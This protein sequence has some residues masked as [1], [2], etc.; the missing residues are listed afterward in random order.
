M[1]KD[2]ESEMEM[3]RFFCDACE[4]GVCTLCTLTT[5]KTHKVIDIKSG[6]N[7]QKEKLQTSLS[8]IQGKVKELEAAL[9]VLVEQQQTIRPDFER[10]KTEIAEHARRRMAD[11]REEERKLQAELVS[12]ERKKNGTLE[13]EVGQVNSMRYIREFSLREAK[14]NVFDGVTASC[15]S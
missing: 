2:H 4:I 7:R 10:L 13:E 6:I 11:I 14:A 1:C 5:H 15:F 12:R 3:L 8:N 9:N